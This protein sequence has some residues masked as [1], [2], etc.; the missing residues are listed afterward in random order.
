LIARREEGGKHQEITL[1][2]RDI[3]GAESF[4]IRWKRGLS[5]RKIEL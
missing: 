2:L 3:A 5:V 1:R 4:Q